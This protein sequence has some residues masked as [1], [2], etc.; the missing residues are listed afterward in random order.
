MVGRFIISNIYLT[1][2]EKKEGQNPIQSS[3]WPYTQKGTTEIEEVFGDGKVFSFPKPVG[4]YMLT[5]SIIVG[6]IK[7]PLCL[8]FFAGS[9]TT[10]YAVSFKST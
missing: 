7:M 5:F 1:K 9:C 10:A 3:M 6:R 2:M 4:S 8:D